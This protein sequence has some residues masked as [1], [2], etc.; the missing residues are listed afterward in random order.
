VIG[1]I[2]QPMPGMVHAYIEAPG[3]RDE[4]LAFYEREYGSRGWR[5]Q[6]PNY[7]QPLGYGFVSAMGGPGGPPQ[8]RVFCKGE[9]GPFYRAD[10]RPGDPPVVAVTYNYGQSGIPHP[11]SKEPFPRMG[12]HQPDVVPTLQGPPGVPIQGGGGGGGSDS[13][14]TSGSALTEMA[15]AVLMDH[16]ASQLEHQGCVLIDRGSAGPVA[17]SRWRL[18]K[19]GWEALVVVIEQSKDLRYLMLLAQSERAQK[20]MR[21][22]QTAS[23]WSSSLR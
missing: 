11:C 16:F 7:P 13:W 14:Q 2:V 17:W 3:D 9:D 12:M 1:S 8:T 6:E 20:Q 5:S 18:K 22:W 23:G 15:A 4:L 10:I 21:T 19:P